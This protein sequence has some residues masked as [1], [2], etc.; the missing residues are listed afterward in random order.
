MARTI[1]QEHSPEDQRGRMM[2]FYA[3]SFMGAGPI[4]ALISGYLVAWFGPSSALAIASLA[5]FAVVISV[6]LRSD[7]WKLT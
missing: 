4:G 6:R 3:F 2:A 5:M 7:L 1:M